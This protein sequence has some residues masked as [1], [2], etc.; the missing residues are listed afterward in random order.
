MKLKFSFSTQAE[1]LARWEKIKQGGIWRFMLLRG[2]LGW[3]FTCG[4]IG[5]VFELTSHKAEAFAWYLILGLFLVAGFVWGLGM[6]FVT[7]W[8]YSRALKS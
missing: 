2:V 3:G 8:S 6:W 5:V 4:I 1:R 7:M